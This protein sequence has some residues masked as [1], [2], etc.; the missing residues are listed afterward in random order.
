M[1]LSRIGTRISPVKLGSVYWPVGR[2][3]SAHN[4]TGL[5]LDLTVGIALSQITHRIDG[6]NPTHKKRWRM[7]DGL[8]HCCTNQL[9]SLLQSQLIPSEAQRVVS[10]VA[11]IVD[12]ILL[13]IL[14][15]IHTDPVSDSHMASWASTKRHGL[16]ICWNRMYFWEAAFYITSILSWLTITCINIQTPMKSTGWNPFKVGSS[17]GVNVGE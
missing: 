2:S 5:E 4:S 17:S 9:R 16:G 10:S 12:S 8:W 14:K 6:W 13:G 15:K 1:A 11:R 7:G 3:R